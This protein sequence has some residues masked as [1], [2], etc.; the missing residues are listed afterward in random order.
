MSATM[1]TENQ[2]WVE[3]SQSLGQLLA[4]LVSKEGKNEF[5]ANITI[6]GGPELENLIELVRVSALSGIMSYILKRKCTIINSSVL[7]H[8]NNVK[9]T[10]EVAPTIPSHYRFG[11]GMIM[12]VNEKE[13]TESLVGFIRQGF[14]VLYSIN[15]SV[16]ETPVPLS[17]RLLIYSKDKTP[18][19]VQVMNGLMKSNVMVNAVYCSKPNNDWFVVSTST[20][21]K[22][23]PLGEG[24]KP[25]VDEFIR[26]S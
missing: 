18:D 7:A 12:G 17:H 20:E 2:P 5:S 19:V 10:V 24:M 8:E 6:Y 15:N 4:A 13:W 26:S 11:E 25:S 23:N 14:A 21:K 3:L 1:S 22:N 16:F 9:M